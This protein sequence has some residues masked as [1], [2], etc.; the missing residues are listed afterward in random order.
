MFGRGIKLLAAA[1]KEREESGNL[2][3]ADKNGKCRRASNRGNRRQPR[4][5]HGQGANNAGCEPPQPISDDLPQIAL[6]T[7]L[8]KSFPGFEPTGRF[9]AQTT[10]GSWIRCSAPSILVGRQILVHPYT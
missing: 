2:R 1:P 7:R 9:G 6:G 10:G 5:W 8:N 3:W 4:E